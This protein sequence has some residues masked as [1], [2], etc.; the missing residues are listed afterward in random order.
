MAIT[1]RLIAAY[2]LIVAVAVAIHFVAESIYP[3]T[4][5]GGEIWQFLNWFMAVS[6]LV[7]LRLR[8]DAM[9]GLDRE[10]S[11]KA[12]IKDYISTNVAFFASVLLTLWYFWNW[13][14][15]LASG[16][17]PQDTVRLVV[18]TLIDPLF[19]ILTGATGRELWMRAGA[20][21]E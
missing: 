12:D 2:L 19:V 11:T 17:E 4:V 13:F 1:K 8:F 9:A 16:S 18:W 10:S 14:D 15:S 21:G 7:T 6:V 3:D 5:D 20:S